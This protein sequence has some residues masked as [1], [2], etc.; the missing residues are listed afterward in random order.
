MIERGV[1]SVEEMT[2]VLK[3]DLEA[4]IGSKIEVA[5]NVFSWIVVHATD[6]INKL[7][8]GR[9]GKTAFE[10]C[11]GKRY[12]GE[13]F[14]FG[15]VVMIRVSGKVAG[16]EMSARFHQ[17]IYLGQRFHSGENIVARLSDGEVVRSRT[18]QGLDVPVTAEMLD[19]IKGSPWMPAG[20][21]KG[22]AEIQRPV[23]PSGDGSDEFN[24]FQ[25]R[26]MQIN[27]SILDAVGYTPG[28]PKCRMTR[29]GDASRPGTS[30]SKECRQRAE[31]AVRANDQLRE[32][33][34]RAE[35]RKNRYLAREL[36]S[37]SSVSRKKKMAS[38]T[39]KFLGHHAVKRIG[40]CSTFQS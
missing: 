26:L 32:R 25:P 30:H 37:T 28:C 15:S 35:Q 39:M 19:K 14:A 17:G 12:K 13:V 33:L 34:E 31:A 11:K 1:R 4:R 3:L 5:S 18:V 20:T 29:L 9:D 2:R 36:G 7:Q 27:K 24:R 38:S 23:M 22:E 10:R 40:R 6:L 8:V 16:G 21:H